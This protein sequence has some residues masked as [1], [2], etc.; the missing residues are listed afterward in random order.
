MSPAVRLELSEREAE[1]VELLLTKELEE[2]RVEVHH[3]RNMEFKEELRDREHLV[4]QL[5]HRL[6]APVG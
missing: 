6:R 3:A 2:T 1:L 4:H 5:L